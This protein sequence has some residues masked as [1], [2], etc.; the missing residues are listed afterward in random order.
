MGQGQ[1]ENGREVSAC[2]PVVTHDKKNDS[3]LESYVICINWLASD[4]IIQWLFS[5]DR[6]GVRMCLF[7]VLSWYSPTETEENYVKL[8]VE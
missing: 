6:K 4:N 1:I 8:Q 5:V 2:E 7:T 3:W